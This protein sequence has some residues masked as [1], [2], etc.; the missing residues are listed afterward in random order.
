[1]TKNIKRLLEI[2]KFWVAFL[3]LWTNQSQNMFRHDFQERGMEM[4]LQTGFLNDIQVKR[5]MEDAKMTICPFRPDNLTPIGYNLSYSRFIVSIRKKTFAKIYHKNNEWFFFLKPAETVLILTR[6]SIWVS[7]FIGGTFHSK[8]S[9]VTKGLGHVS[10]TLDPGWQGQLLVPLNNPTKEKIKVVIAKDQ[11]GVM[12]YD[13]FITMVLYWSAEASLNEKMDNKSARIEILEEIIEKK[14]TSKDDEKL[15]EIIKE[16]RDSAGHTEIYENLN[17]PTKRKDKIKEFENSH[18]ELLR[19]MDG[20]FDHINRISTR[21]Y[22]SS[23]IAFMVLT[24]FLIAVIV[25][26]ITFGFHYKNGEYGEYVNYIVSALVPFVILG[27]T[28]VKSKY[29]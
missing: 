8:V 20:Q 1:M 3:D 22:N 6:E 15:R 26:L 17:D 2:F 18:M 4:N 7:K 12:E 24:I 13:S 28:H 9:L 5:A 23:M 29:I 25:G 16:L 21:N 27:L 14:K 11:N 19:K 10:T